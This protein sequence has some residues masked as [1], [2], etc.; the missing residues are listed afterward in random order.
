MGDIIATLAD[1][2]DVSIT[3]GSALFHFDRDCGKDFFHLKRRATE[4]MRKRLIL[5][6]VLIAIACL[7]SFSGMAPD[8]GPGPSAETPAATEA[9]PQLARDQEL[10][11]EGPT[12]SKTAD[13]RS[14]DDTPGCLT[15][16]ELDSN[17][18]IRQDGER[19]HSVATNGPHIEIFRGVSEGSLRSFAAQG[20]SAA[21][22]VLGARSVMRALGLD[23]HRAV[24]W[25]Q[26]EDLSTETML[27]GRT[28]SESALLELDEAAVWF[29]RAAMHGRLYALRNY[30]DVMY[31]RYGGPVGLDWIT[32][33]DFRLVSNREKAAL[34]P[35][36]VYQNVANDVA[37]QLTEGP[38]GWLGDMTI[39]A[40]VEGQI[41]N[42]LVGEFL[43]ARDAAGL[44]PISVAD[45]ASP[46]IDALL[47]KL[48][49][50]E[51]A[52]LLHRESLQ[53][54][55]GTSR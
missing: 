44:P 18:L 36:N 5:F 49:E 1:R 46:D 35:S 21:M 34:A 47:A 14:Q 45:T 26:F 15:E 43:K 39:R 4:A 10:E 12:Q 22:A 54:A 52:E 42:E 7:A 40:D 31:A 11:A 29:Y 41:R 27:P 13:Q 19:F 48:C 30:G 8:P 20:D 50:S 53:E 2:C 23:E 25:L 55:D 32:E 24:S 38:I 6:G 37:P 16:R 28:F 33:D 17:P 9:Q 3:T 51:K